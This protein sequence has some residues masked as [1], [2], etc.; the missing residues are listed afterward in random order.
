MLTPR[1]LD[2]GET[3]A[4]SSS[5]LSKKIT[6][7]PWPVSLH[8]A[9]QRQAEHVSRPDLEP[10]QDVAGGQRRVEDMERYFIA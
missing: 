5:P 1:S 8:P 10:A 4:A 3:C 7:L 6:S 9:I 2:Q